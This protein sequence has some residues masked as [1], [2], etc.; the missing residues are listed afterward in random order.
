MNGC[1][2]PTVM[3]GHSE[4]GANCQIGYIGDYIGD[5]HL[6]PIFPGRQRLTLLGPVG[7]GFVCPAAVR[8]HFLKELLLFFDVFRC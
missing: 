2:D 3:G 1:G 4:N 7:K 5:R 8:F 6:F